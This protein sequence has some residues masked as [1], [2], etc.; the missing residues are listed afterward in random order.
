MRKEFRQLA[1]VEEAIEVAEKLTPERQVEDVAL[2]RAHGRVLAD[3]LEAAIDVPGFDR[4]LMDGYALRAEDSYG[5]DEEEPVA[6]Q[7]SGDVST[8]EPAAVTVEG[9]EAVEIAT[10]APIPEG[11]DS[12]VPVERTERDGE[13]V[14]LDTAL[15]PGD[16]VMYAGSDVAA[17]SRALSRGTKLSQR[18]IGLAAA[19]GAETLAVYRRPCVGVVSTGD[20][21]V[22]PGGDLDVGQIHDVNT[23]SVAAAV[24]E[25]DGE[26]EVYPHVED[27]YDRMVEVMHNAAED[28]DLVLSSGS[29]S[30][31][32]GDVVYRV[33][34]EEGELL[35]HGVSLKPG[36]PTVFGALDGTSFVGLPG[37]PISALSVFRMFVAGMVRHA[38]GRPREPERRTVDAV[39]A[40]EVRTEGG[41]TRLLPVGLVEDGTGRL[42]AYS[43]DRGSGATTSLTLADGYV[44]VEPRTNYLDEGEDVEVALLGE[45][46]GP[47]LLG[48]GEDDAVV[49]AALGEV[50][51]RWLDVG[52]VEAA[53]RL[54]DGVVDVAV[55]GLSPEEVADV[56][57]EGAALLRGYERRVGWAGDPDSA[58][59]FGVQ[60]DGYALRR[61]FDEE[62]SDADVRVYR[63]E[64]GAANAVASGKVDAALVGENLA[65]GDVK[66]HPVGWRG[67]D[68]L[69]SDD[70]REK[71]GVGSFLSAMQE[72]EQKG[73]RLPA[74]SGEVVERWDYA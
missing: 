18:E 29:T 54:R 61:W 38:A 46:T 68:V 63:S 64:R 7:V 4:S 70:R 49:G 32:E 62:R 66:F 58:E 27:D 53:R 59:V 2:R 14:H 3:D 11:A 48:A 37:N 36:R 57:V 22:R 16:N 23:Y 55:V 33:V 1:S 30:A 69:V 17:G 10:G 5:A 24:E 35:L 51:G 52:S 72:V 41:R 47:E 43:V 21:L 15:A 45:G 34:E 8:G 65:S 13:V 56:G 50:D 60:P 67:F 31:S 42:L 28:C 26:A 71:P 73:Y 40:D 9:G 12:V 19:V 74:D 39:L 20:E 6:L 25:A 44:T